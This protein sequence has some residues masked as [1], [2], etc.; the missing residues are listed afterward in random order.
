MPVSYEDPRQS[1]NWLLSPSTPLPDTDTSAA[2][3]AVAGG[4][5]GSGFSQNDRLRLRDTERMKRLELG[6][7]L[8]QPY[9]QRDSAEKMQ[10]TQIAADASRQAVSEAGLNTR[11]SAENQNRL[12]LALISGNQQAAHD[13]LN[14][15]GLDRRQA[16]QISANLFQSKQDNQLKL[17]SS[18]LPYAA[19][20][21][22]GSPGGATL[23]TSSAGGAFTSGI[24][25]VDAHGNPS[26]PTTAA[27][28]PNAHGVTSG[29]GIAGLTPAI[30][31]ILR[32]YG[33][34]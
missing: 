12:N 14:E 16:A 21:A 10:Q 1:L 32:S 27:Y 4:V 24:F 34:T 25:P 23:G 17:L 11:L 9:L 19:G 33:L 7:T 28:N 22:G 3:A 6:Q 26:Y 5:A 29:G 8:L 31:S 18:L 15:A 30:N 20:R 2:A 13:L